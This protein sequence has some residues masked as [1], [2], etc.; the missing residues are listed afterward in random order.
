MPAQRAE[1]PAVTRLSFHGASNGLIC[2]LSG[3]K[4]RLHTLPD[5]VTPATRAFVTRLG[6]SELEE[7]AE[8]LFQ[9][10]RRAGPYKRREITLDSREGEAA[11][12]TPHF[13]L[14]LTLA[15]DEDEPTAYSLGSHLHEL[16]EAGIL[17]GE[18]M[19]AALAGRF[20]AL[21]FHLARGWQVEAVIDAV[22]EHAPAGTELDYPSDC[23]WCALSTAGLPASI[24]CDAHGLEL[25]LPAPTHPAALA[26]AYAAMRE[27]IGG[28]NGLSRFLP[29]LT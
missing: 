26:E 7:E 19:S 24:H 25:R 29:A 11:V 27:Q 9:D 18:A 3:F 23:A 12:R 22:E 2:G 28:G 6:K 14:E 20:E 16:A 17:R 13:T 21:R 4:K 1:T 5:S 8:Q 15:Q 10:I